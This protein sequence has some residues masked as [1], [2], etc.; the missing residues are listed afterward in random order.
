MVECVRCGKETT[1]KAEDYPCFSKV[2]GYIL[3]PRVEIDVCLECGHRSLSPEAEQEVN[4]WLKIREQA[5]ICSLSAEQ[6]LSAGQAAEM[7]GVTKQA[8]SKS[9]KVKKGHIYFTTIGNKKVYFRSSVELFKETGD[10]RY[11]ISKWYSSLG[12]KRTA[13]HESSTVKWHAEE[14]IGASEYTWISSYSG[15]R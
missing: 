7:L 9:P 13:M 1:R 14:T 8:F 6:L 5:A 3:A 11:Q 4:S 10:G 2:L 15:A 12:S